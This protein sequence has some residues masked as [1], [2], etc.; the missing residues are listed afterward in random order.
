MVV[1]GGVGT[2][3]QDGGGG[4]VF[5]PTFWCFDNLCMWLNEVWGGVRCTCCDKGFG[6]F[7]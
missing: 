2:C 1:D 3:I 5:F 4:N 7:M 6:V